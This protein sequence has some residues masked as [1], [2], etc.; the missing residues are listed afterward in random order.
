M[1]E[2]VAIR[3]FRVAEDA[4]P[5]AEDA[6]DGIAMLSDLPLEFRRRI[7]EC[8]RVI[9][10]FAEDL[11]PARV[12]EL[13]EKIDDFRR[14]LLKLLERDTRERERDPHLRMSFE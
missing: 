3:K 11:Y 7:E 8:E 1:A 5:D 9:V 4:R 13:F 12:D 6:P 10:G 14:V 2:I